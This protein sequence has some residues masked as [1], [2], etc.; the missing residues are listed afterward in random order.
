MSHAVYS[1]YL[2]VNPEA[3][4]KE[5]KDEIRDAFEVF[6][7][8]L[9]ENNWFTLLSAVTQDNREFFFETT[10]WHIPG[11][12][13]WERGR[14]FAIGTVALDMGVGPDDESLEDER[15]FDEL[16]E[17]IMR[18]VPKRLSEMY[19]RG[20][21]W[22]DVDPDPDVNRDQFI[23]RYER[24]KW[25]QQFERFLMS[26]SYYE[27]PFAGDGTPYDYRCFDLSGGAPAEEGLIPAILFVDIH[28]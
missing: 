12:N 9:D 14:R 11:P 5:I 24:G 10:D 20:A 2:H 28:T 6:Q 1:F 15:N 18:V 22:P 17:A 27:C 3:P 25:A 7:D 16:K 21:L 4:D 26:L 23:T 19:A 13:V 8:R